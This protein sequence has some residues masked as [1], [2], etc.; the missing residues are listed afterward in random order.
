MYQAMLR[1]GC[2]AATTRMMNDM[3]LTAF[4]I[5]YAVLGIL[6]RK[7]RVKEA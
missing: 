1:E 6:F 2:I 5:A 7:R 4:A 3:V